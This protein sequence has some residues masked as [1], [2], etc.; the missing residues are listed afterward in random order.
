MEA[1]R[2]C[3]AC[4]AREKRA[5][6]RRVV[7]VNNEYVFDDKASM[8]GRGAWVHDSVECVQKAIS[9]NTFARALRVAASVATHN[10]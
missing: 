8:P 6:L 5:G 4:R 10:L 1:I 7:V 2:T 3:V 9:R